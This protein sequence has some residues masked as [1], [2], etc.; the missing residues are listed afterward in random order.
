MADD[1]ACSEGYRVLRAK[2][3]EHFD[4]KIPGQWCANNEIYFKPT[5]NAYQK[6]FQ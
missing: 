1:N 3:E 2:V 6:D 4:N 5:N